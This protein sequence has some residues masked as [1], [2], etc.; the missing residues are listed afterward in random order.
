MCDLLQQIL[1]QYAFAAFPPG[2]SECAQASRESLLAEVG[3]IQQA[4]HDETQT[5][6]MNRR[7]RVMAKAAIAYYCEGLDGATAARES[8]LCGMLKG[9]SVHEAGY[10]TAQQRDETDK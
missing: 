3:R 4:W 6:S 8:Y 1:R 5:A 9:E 10:R 2:G 7:I